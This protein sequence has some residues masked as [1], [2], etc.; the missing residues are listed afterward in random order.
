MTTL[1]EWLWATLLLAL[2]LLSHPSFAIA[3]GCAVAF[4]TLG[5]AAAGKD[6]LALRGLLSAALYGVT[7]W[8]AVWMVQLLYESWRLAQ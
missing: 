1:L 7:T 5:H 3:A 8:V 2:P 4:Y 6:G